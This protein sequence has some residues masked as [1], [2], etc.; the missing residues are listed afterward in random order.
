[1]DNRVLYRNKTMENATSGIYLTTE[2]GNAGSRVVADGG[3]L[4]VTPAWL[5]D[6]S[7]FVYT[8]DHEIRQYLFAGSD[9]KQLA[10]FYDDYVFNPSVSPDG[11]YVVF[12]WQESF[13]GGNN[14][15]LWVLD[16]DKPTQLWVVT[17]DNRSTN[18]DWSRVNVPPPS[19]CIALQSVA[20]Q[21][22]ASGLT[23]INYTFSVST[24]PANASAPMSY[25]WSPKP[26]SGQGAAQ[27]TYKW[28][29][30]GKHSV[31][32]NGSNCGGGAVNDSHSITIRASGPLDKN[33]YLPSLVRP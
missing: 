10:F 31:S 32:V 23:G 16:R 7:G 29:A 2:D 8:S 24:Q 21:G 22:P 20:I 3:A 19:S 27:A 12:Q 6:G 30:A 28:T 13:T 26:A 18:P 4:W 15:N 11:K 33:V 5:P 14:H 17:N 25:D 1:M 9:D